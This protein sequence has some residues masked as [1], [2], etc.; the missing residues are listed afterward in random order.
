MKNLPKLAILAFFLALPLLVVAR[1]PKLKDGTA[2]PFD[3]N[4]T[5]V[6]LLPSK[7]QAQITFWYG[8]HIS[9]GSKTVVEWTRDTTVNVSDSISLRYLIAAAARDTL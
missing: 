5:D 6:I 1:A 8:I 4:R 9:R 7:K 2:I 3:T